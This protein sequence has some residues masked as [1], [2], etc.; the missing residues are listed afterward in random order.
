[1]TGK[2]SR[3]A[4]AFVAILALVVTAIPAQA[5][6]DEQ[7]WSGSDRVA[8]AVEVSRQAFEQADVVL[9]ANDRGFADALAAAPLAGAAGAPVL[10][11]AADELDPRVAAEVDRLGP[12]LVYVLGGTAALSEDVEDDLAAPGRQVQRVRGQDRFATAVE[13]ARLAV[14]RWQAD[15]DPSA[16]RTVLIALGDHP[17]GDDRAWPDALASGVLAGNR[18]WPLLLVTRDEVP[19]VTAAALEDLGATEA[20]VVG[21]T[22]AISEATADRLGVPYRRVR[23]AS[24]YG[25]GVALTE[26]AVSAGADAGDVTIVTGRGFPDAL[27]AVPA[28]LARGGVLLLVDGLDLDGA[29]EARD[30][31]ADHDVTQVTVVGGTSVVTDRV[32]QQVAAAIHGTTPPAPEPV[33]LTTE[34]VVSA[35]TPLAVRSDTAEPDVLYV[36]E[37]AGRVLRHDAS[38]TTTF[39]DL[40]DRVGTRGEQGLLDLV[41][42]PDFASNGRFFVHYSDVLNGDTVLSEFRRS[43]SDP[44]RASTTEMELYRT[45]QPA[46]NHN[47]GGL[48][49]LPDGTLLLA[50]G[51]GGGANDQFR[52]GQNL[53]TPLGSLLRF[54]VSTPGEAAIPSDNPYVGQP[55]ADPRI[56]ASGLRN[57]F[58]ISVDAPSGVLYVGDVGQDRREEINAVTWNAAGLDY[59]WST[60]EGDRCFPNGGTCDRTGLQPPA[61]VYEHGSGGV[62]S[63]AGGY[64]H[65]GAITS[66]RGHYFYGD[67]CGG[68]VW[69]FRLEGGQATDQR[70]WSDQIDVG[71]VYSFGSDARGETYVLNASGV[72]RIVAG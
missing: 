63:V 55:G 45:L 57:P 47:G 13:A 70:D 51:D 29:P 36:A 21:G 30:W 4:T 1:M 67:F 35:Q 5:T 59:G 66:L 33:T 23:G 15:G 34:L 9:V 71:N 64:V 19:A 68:Q 41:L 50:L 44:A 27:G 6:H 2:R 43:A 53:S 58:R 60:V 65:R 32:V 18:H 16:G 40:R 56:W 61:V 54:D 11:T 25:T 49:F 62:C 69:S 42:H 10:L 38:G 26:E 28:V 22:S 7:R 24:R 12:D 46:S 14:Q 3:I 8:T 31:L 72:H 39:L 48:A 52:N 17:L 37:L 20:V